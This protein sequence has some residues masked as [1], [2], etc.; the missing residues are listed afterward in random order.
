MRNKKILDLT[1][2]SIR[3]VRLIS[4][5]LGGILAW[6]II[7]PIKK[8]FITYLNNIDV[9]ILLAI[10][11]IFMFN[12]RTYGT[13]TDLRTIQRNFVNSHFSSFPKRGWF[14]MIIFGIIYTGLIFSIKNTLLFTSLLIAFWVYNAIFWKFFSKDMIT[15]HKNNYKEYSNDNSF[16]DK[17][18]MKICWNYFVKNNKWNRTRHLTIL[19]FLALA[20]VLLATGYDKTLENLIN[21]NNDGLLVSFLL[22]IA[23]IF[24]EIFIWVKR[25]KMKYHIRYMEDVG[26]R[27]KLK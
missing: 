25:T 19:S 12:S 9:G 18:K 13:I 2:I 21:V 26:R 20:L 16:V 4:A 6:V 3:N 8:E 23:T 27:Y 7:N 17:E 10:L 24:G 14:P 11:L 5:S 15:F 22:V 1:K